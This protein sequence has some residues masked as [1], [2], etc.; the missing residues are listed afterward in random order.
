MGTTSRRWVG[1]LKFDS[2]QVGARSGA[3]F[4]A[5]RAGLS[6]YTGHVLVLNKN[7]PKNTQV[8]KSFYKTEN[9]FHAP[10]SHAQ[11]LRASKVKDTT[12]STRPNPRAW[13]KEI[14]AL[15]H[16]GQ[17]IGR[18]AADQRQH[19]REGGPHAVRPAARRP[20]CARRTSPRLCSTRPAR[21]G[22]RTASRRLTEKNR[23]HILHEVEGHGIHSCWKGGDDSV[24]ENPMAQ[25][26]HRRDVRLQ[27]AVSVLSW[28]QGAERL[29]ALAAV[30]SALQPQVRAALSHWEPELVDIVATTA[31]AAP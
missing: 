11:A 12:R 27:D 7:A 1:R 16:A 20:G 26:R 30:A 2:T 19:A 23:E 29:L 17:I 15:R 5:C 18:A 4:T 8:G 6:I 28:F 25:V 3:I 9:E 22:T 10:A 13:A 31:G 24:M 21:R 14:L